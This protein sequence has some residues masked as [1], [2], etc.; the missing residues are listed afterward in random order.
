MEIHLVEMVELLKRNTLVDQGLV[1]EENNPSYQKNKSE[2]LEI[3]PNLPAPPKRQKL[4]RRVGKGSESHNYFAL[5]KIPK[6][7][8]CGNKSV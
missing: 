6:K 5:I 2:S 3:L 7:L 4:S 1:D 8:Q